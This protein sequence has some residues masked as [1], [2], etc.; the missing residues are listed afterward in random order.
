MEFAAT[1]PGDSPTYLYVPIQPLSHLEDA[2]RSITLGDVEIR[3]LEEFRH[4]SPPGEIQFADY[5][6]AEWQASSHVIPD[7][8][9]NVDRT[10]TVMSHHTWMLMSG[11]RTILI[12]TA[13]GNGKSR[14]NVPA[15]DN[16][17]TDYLEQLAKVGATP[18]A[19]DLVV[20]THL[21]FDHVGWHTRLVDDQ[22]IPTFPNARYLLPR[23]DVEYWSPENDGRVARRG[24]LIMTNV[25]ADSIAPIFEAGLVDVWDEEYVIDE[26][27]RL[28]SAPG[29]TPGNCIVKL[30]SV[31]ETAVF[32]GDMCQSA[33]QFA[34]PEM[35]SAFDEDP[36]QARLSRRRVLDW[37]ADRSALVFGGHF[38]ADHAA[39]LGRGAGS[40][41]VR[42]W[43]ALD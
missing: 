5:D 22:W 43:R 33:V 42:G 31:D 37:A 11:G 34:L 12:D 19:V 26:N 16:L 29:H 18:T 20:T 17:K 36:R 28:E 13:L 14:P 25:W 4:E 38:G 32:I 23:A 40:V 27:L 7:C 30:T 8:D 6:D 15:F 41:E 39:E 9:W 24:E 21:H 1:L 10:N 3:R 35:T 2:V